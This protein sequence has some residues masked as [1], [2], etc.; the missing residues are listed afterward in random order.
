M[1]VAALAEAGA[2][3]GRDDWITAAV[4]VTGASCSPHLR[5]RRTA[6]G[7]A[8]GRPKPAPSTSRWPATTPGWSTPSPASARPPATR[9]GR[10][11]PAPPPTR[12]LDLFWDPDARRPVHRRPRRPGARSPT[13]RRPSTAPPRRPTPSARSRWLAWRAHRR[14]ALRRTRPGDRRRAARRRSPRRFQPRIVRRP[15]P[16]DRRHRGRH[17]RPRRRR[18]RARRRLS[19]RVAA[20]ALCSRGATRSTRR[21]WEGRSEGNA[22]VCRDFVCALPATDPEALAAQLG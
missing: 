20:A 6:A 10:T 8:P 13:P 12:M 17:P 2:A 3:F 21:L 7:C 11:R 9:A 16:G 15:P 14:R 4:G 19:R 5:T 18:D 22:Y 1:F